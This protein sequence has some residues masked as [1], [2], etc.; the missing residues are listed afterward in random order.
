MYYIYF[1]SN[2]VM[3]NGTFYTVH[4]S[5]QSWIAAI[6]CESTTTTLT[7]LHNQTENVLQN[8]DLVHII[9]GNKKGELIRELISNTIYLTSTTQNKNSRCLQTGVYG[10][11]F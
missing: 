5:L 10:L 9:D 7:Q 11:E 3:M 8:V 2:N 1:C 4:F 6:L